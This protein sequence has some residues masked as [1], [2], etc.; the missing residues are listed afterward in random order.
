ME[1]ILNAARAEARM[2]RQQKAERTHE[3][4]DDDELRYSTG[5]PTEK[6][7]AHSSWRD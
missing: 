2:G 6:R 5:V 3:R 1:V 4:R 7:R